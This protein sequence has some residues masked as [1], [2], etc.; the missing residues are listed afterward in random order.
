MVA[1]HPVGTRADVTSPQDFM[2]VNNET[3]ITWKPVEGAVAYRIELYATADGEPVAAQQ[4]KGNTLDSTL[5]PLVL[6]KLN[7]K[8]RYM[9][10]VY[11][12]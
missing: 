12:E 5:S 3:R 4:V 8:R 10:R 2:P 11:A 6:E 9:V 1:H 7:P